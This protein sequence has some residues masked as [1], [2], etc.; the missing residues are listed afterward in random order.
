[1]FLGM[2]TKVSLDLYE[3][4]L[5]ESK[6]ES[7]SIA[8]SQE[9]ENLYVQDVLASKEK[10]L[11]SMLEK[12]SVILICGSIQMGKSVLQVLDTIL[13]EN[14]NNDTSHLLESGHIKMDCY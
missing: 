13:L 14:F 1:M 9:E 12:K 2:R 4:Y 10:F 5:K 11:K 8:Y 7:I 6:L 3:P